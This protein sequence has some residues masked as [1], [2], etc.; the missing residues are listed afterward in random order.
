M[1]FCLGVYYEF[2][3][4]RNTWMVLVFINPVAFVGY[5]TDDEIFSICLFFFM[6][7][8]AMVSAGKY[9]IFVFIDVIA[10]RCRVT[11]ISGRMPV[12][13]VAVTVF[14]A[15]LAFCVHAVAHF[16]AGLAG[17]VAVHVHFFG[18]IEVKFVFVEIFDA[19]RRRSILNREVSIFIVALYAVSIG[20]IAGIKTF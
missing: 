8:G 5:V 19:I 14:V 15:D 13:K 18:F 2:V 16:Q 17:N 4:D 3:A 20:G 11:T 6:A 9:P 1:S 10:L 12:D 7:N